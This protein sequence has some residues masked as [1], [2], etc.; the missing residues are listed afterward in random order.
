AWDSVLLLEV[1]DVMNKNFT[2]P[3]QRL[4]AISCSLLAWV[5]LCPPC[6]VLVLECNRREV[7]QSMKHSIKHSRSVGEPLSFYYS[8]IVS[9][10]TTKRSHIR[11][12]MMISLRQMKRRM[13]ID[14]RIWLRRSSL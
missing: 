3:F 7:N 8:L 1:C 13:R 4:E 5:S 9:M 12:C 11:A 2:K 6:S 10:C 14:T